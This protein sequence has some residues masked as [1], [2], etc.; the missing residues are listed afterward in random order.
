[1]DRDTI[2]G[3]DRDKKRN[4]DMVMDEDGDMVGVRDTVTGT[5]TDS[6]RGTGGRGVV[7]PRTAG[8]E[9]VAH[10]CAPLPRVGEVLTS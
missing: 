5:D 7:A 1:M 4:R 9:G 10:S 3:G 2:M 6:A 8:R